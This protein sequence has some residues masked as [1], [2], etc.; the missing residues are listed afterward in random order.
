MSDDKMGK[1]GGQQQGDQQGGASRSP[2]SSKA[3]NR[4]ASRSPASNN[5]CPDAKV[6]NRAVAANRAASKIVKI[7]FHAQIGNPPALSPGDFLCTA[8]LL[9]GG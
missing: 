8:R 3:V 7:E 1:Q 5:R 4:V 2:A 9:R 6:A